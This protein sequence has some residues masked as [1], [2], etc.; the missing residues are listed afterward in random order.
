MNWQ[1]IETAPKDR[2]MSEPMTTTRLRRRVAT[3]ADPE[4]DETVSIYFAADVETAL[5][6]LVQQWREEAKRLSEIDEF[7]AANPVGGSEALDACADQ[8]ECLILGAE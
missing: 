2:L 6:S 7:V 3:V 8:L 4:C 1:P 5:R